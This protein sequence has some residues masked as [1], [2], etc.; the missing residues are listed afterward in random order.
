[1]LHIPCFNSSLLC[2]YFALAEAHCTDIPLCPPL[3]QTDSRT[4]SRDVWGVGA[5]EKAA[6]MQVTVLQH[7]SPHPDMWGTAAA[8]CGESLIHAGADLHLPSPQ[9]PRRQVSRCALQ[10]QLTL[11]GW[12]ACVPVGV[13]L[14]GWHPFGVCVRVPFE[15]V[16][17]MQF[18]KILEIP[19]FQGCLTSERTAHAHRH[20]SGINICKVLLAAHTVT[21][22]GA[23]QDTPTAR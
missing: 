7:I 15:A 14:Q 19:E 13:L 12:S 16:V 10:I 4:D 21:L 23:R 1:M 3:G 18:P 8:R 2:V 11:K 9:V 22:T 17:L 6:G 20:C 5:R